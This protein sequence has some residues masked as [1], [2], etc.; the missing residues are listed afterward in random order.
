[1]EHQLGWLFSLL[2]TLVWIVGAATALLALRWSWKKGWRRL[3]RIHGYHGLVT[4][5]S[6]LALPVAI[7]SVGHTSG[8]GA[9]KLVRIIIAAPPVML[10]LII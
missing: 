3:H 7:S 2:S 1:M 4:I 8:F 10:T 6:I 9:W 5:P